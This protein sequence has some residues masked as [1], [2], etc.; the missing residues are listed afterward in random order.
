MRVP[1]NLPIMGL[2]LH[3]YLVASALLISLVSSPG[4]V[5]VIVGIA[6]TAVYFYIF[7]RESKSFPISPLALHF[8]WYSLG[9]GVACIYF[10]FAMLNEE[11]IIFY[12]TSL[13]YRDIETALLLS[14]IG[15]LAL[16]V[17][18]NFTRPQKVLAS[19]RPS[20]IHPIATLLLFAVGLVAL[21]LSNIMPG[22]N[23]L[24]I[25]FGGLG[26]IV[27]YLPYAI[28]M[29]LSWYPNHPRIL[30][31]LITGTILILPA[32]VLS[33]SKEYIML[34][35][36]PLGFWAWKKSKSLALVYGL[37]LILLYLSVVAPLV[38]SIRTLGHPEETTI[39]EQW[40]GFMERVFD[41]EPVAYIVQDVKLQ[42]FQHGETL[43]NIVYTFVPRIA[44]PD[45]PSMAHSLWF[46]A[47]IGLAGS[48]EAANTATAMTAPG[49]LYLNF[50]VP[51]I[52]VGMLVIG[53]MYGG[54]F[55]IAV[56]RF[57]LHTIKGMLIAI[58]CSTS[59]RTGE[60]GSMIVQALTLYLFVFALAFAQKQYRF[61]FK[62][63]TTNALTL[64]QY[65]A[66]SPQP[67]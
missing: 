3:A 27:M 63:R 12:R 55:K 20:K 23:G 10:G 19:S 36:L 16:H 4:D 53:A 28:L 18:L 65:S 7:W 32:A 43:S 14:L 57:G 2:M 58:I 33:A 54:L 48:P 50:G 41:L 67:E 61:I 26:G 60:A 25:G 66:P 31:K 46:S 1:A 49:E 37:S 62:P 30:L 24:P 5:L 59:M 35:L 15:S 17:A 44:W 29:R 39:Y 45:K 40:Q 51:G 22:Q 11:P 21:G 42:G 38:N 52:V 6:S 34:A 8:L 56:S 47:Y 13:E 9:Y 64:S